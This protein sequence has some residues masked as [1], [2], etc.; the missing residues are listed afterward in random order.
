ME[1]TGK[2]LFKTNGLTLTEAPTLTR[3]RQHEKRGVRS[4]K[5]RGTI[6]VAAISEERKRG[7]SKEESACTEGREMGNEAS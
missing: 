6:L 5:K 7:G 1:L 2:H 4:K 3:S